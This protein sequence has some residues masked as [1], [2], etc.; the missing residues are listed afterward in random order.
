MPI[1]KHQMDFY[2]PAAKT[3]QEHSMEEETDGH[4]ANLDENVELD[5]KR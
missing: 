4:D 1:I 5:Y 2:Q 3:L